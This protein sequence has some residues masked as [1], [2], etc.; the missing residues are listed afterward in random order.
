M[1]GF[2]G[3]H[4]GLCRTLLTQMSE[5]A[6]SRLAPSFC[7]TLAGQWLQARSSS[8]T[9][10]LAAILLDLLTSLQAAALAVEDE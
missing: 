2:E 10:S 5:F 6:E 9:P 3:F 7:T 8:S 1:A 4:A